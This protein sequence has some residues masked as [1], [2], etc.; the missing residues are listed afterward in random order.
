MK[1]ILIKLVLVLTGATVFCLVQPA[2]AD[3]VVQA[4]PNVVT[5]PDSGSS[6]SLLG[7]A[8]LGVAA[9]GR[10]LSRQ[11]NPRRDP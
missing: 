4:G 7:L 9:L 3:Q 5:V 8:L 10:K 6:I 2:K 11:V 1:R